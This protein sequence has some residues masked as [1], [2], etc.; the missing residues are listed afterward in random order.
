MEVPNIIE[1]G[2]ALWRILHTFAEQI[3]KRGSAGDHNWHHQEYELWM[4]LLGVLSESM[5]CA[6]CQTHYSG[7]IREN[8]YTDA[9]AVGTGEC[10]RV[11]VRTWLWT[12][13]N[14]VRTRK[15]QN[16]ILSLEAIP[17]I[18]SSYVPSKLDADCKMVLSHMGRAAYV[19]IIR[20]DMMGRFTTI[21]NNMRKF[22]D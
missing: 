16:T 11:A 12:L 18:Y 7:Y 8:P 13:H 1:W 5:P 20:Q 21:I 3:G 9:F 10:R 22:Y 19:R 6:S 4:A 17:F 15:G 14:N 2:P